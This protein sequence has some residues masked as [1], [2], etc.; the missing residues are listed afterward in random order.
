M[1]DKIP[2]KAKFDLDGNAVALAEFEPGDTITATIISE[3]TTHRFATDA[4]KTYWNS[5]EAGGAAAAAQAAAA[6][7][8]TAKAAAAQAAAI[9]TASA[10]A[11]TKVAAHE[12][13]LDPHPQYA[14]DAALSSGLSGKADLVGGV[15]P[16]S[17]L[18]SYVDDVLEVADFAALPVTG[19]TG[20][21]YVTLSDNNSWRWTG[22]TYQKVSQPLDEMPQAVAEAGTSETLYAATSRRIRQAIAAWWLTA[23]SVFGRTLA[24]VADAAAGRTALGLGTAATATVTTSATDTTA[25]RLLK[26]GDFGLGG[27]PDTL[28]GSWN[29]LAGESRF[30]R[31]ALNITTD[32]PFVGAIWLQG[33]YL[34]TTASNGTFFGST[35]S[36][37]SPRYFMRSFA[38]GAW[39]AWFEIPAIGF[40]AT[41]A[42]L[43]AT[44]NTTL[45][46]SSSDTVTTNGPVGVMTAASAS[47]GLYVRPLATLT[48]TA[49]AG[50]LSYVR[51]SAEATGAVDAF[52]ARAET[53]AGS[54]T[55][56]RTSGLVVLDAVKGAGSTITTAY[57]VWILDQTQGTNNYGITSEVSAGA[58]KRNLNIT[59][60]A[61]N[62]L[63]GNTGIG[64][65]GPVAR[66]DVVGGATG[67]ETV[68]GIL[69]SNF[70]AN[71]TGVTLRLTN[72]TTALTNVGSVELAAVRTN[73]GF[74]GATDAI[75]RSCNSAG[76]MADRLKLTSTGVVDVPSGQIKFPATQNPS[77]D[78]NTLDDYEEGTFTPTI[79]G[80]TTAGAGTYTSQVGR[81][82][83]VGN[84]VFVS[85]AV[86]WSAHTGTGNIAIAG[87]PF[88]TNATSGVLP[89]F[90]VC[91]SYLTYAG[92][93]VAYAAPS[94]TQ[95]TLGVNA[96][97]AP[98]GVVPMDTA[99]IRISGHYEV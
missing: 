26:V 18:P 36:T 86:T 45:G 39:G 11:T 96:S 35:L 85:I 78:A 74:T 68:V 6:L 14:T 81:Y 2:L 94:Q 97:G 83:K 13:L 31:G 23:S 70:T 67:A 52:Y 48:G 80:T 53:S 62:V 28:T 27:T 57:G 21:I 73:A 9:A 42:N 43:I 12:A 40:N 56:G 90:T 88:V 33:V 82:T 61:D 50:V 20:K 41:F 58:N 54:Q 16:S 44:G 69:R 46:N 15:V 59:G 99:H 65:A 34:K 84:R 66:L 22:S 10:D 17:Q 87:L 55:T 64:T 38:S 63:M 7:D 79:I 60:T 4:E 24:N 51:G 77:A 19:E 98:L 72:S 8:A 75:I 95:V 89:V 91:S 37:T 71:G 25:G 30:V 1:A 32:G 76:V 3:D 29:D 47:V 92:E 93:L 5:K 49:Q